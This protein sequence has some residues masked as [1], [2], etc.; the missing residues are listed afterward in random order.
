MDSNDTECGMR[1]DS[2]TGRMV[3][4]AMAISG[5]AVDVVMEDECG[6]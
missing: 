1:L 5:L 2:R 4:L 3:V 6:Y